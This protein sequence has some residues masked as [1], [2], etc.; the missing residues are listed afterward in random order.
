MTAR[1]PIKTPFFYGWL[2]VGVTFLVSFSEVAF[3]QPV[4][5]V[6]MSPL[7]EEFGWSRA[8]IAGAIGLGSIA[9]GLTSTVV[10]PIIDTWGGRWVMAATGLVI[11]AAL[12]LLAGAHSVVVFYIC[13]IIGRAATVSAMSLAA[14]VTV[15][16]WFIRNRGLAIGV[17]NLGSRI[18]QAVVPPLMAFLVAGFGWRSAFVA[19]GCIALVLAVLPALVFVRRRPE[20]VGLYPDGMPLSVTLA[21]PVQR[22]EVDWSAR[23]A[24]RTRAFWMLTLATSLGSMASA[25]VHLHT[26]PY[27]QDRGLPT[28]V[29]VTVLSL[30]A[31]IGGIGGLFGGLAERLVGARRTFALSLAGQ[32]LSMVILINV[33]SIPMAYL[34]ALCFG[35]AFGMTFT[36]NNMI[37]ATYFGRRSLG[38]IRGLAS[39][40][41]LVFNAAGPFLS[42]LVYDLTGSYLLAFSGFAVSYMVGVCCVLLAAQPVSRQTAASQP[43][44]A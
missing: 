19:L 10:G 18:G 42:G 14:S 3:F 1:V 11:A 9:G 37:F 17:M 5:G 25:S 36:M 20:D 13:Y 23:A 8:T 22:L 24:I 38:A 34:F 4:L 44:P 2:I 15:S 21:T 41:Q 39:P 35:V 27:L 43:A 32:A 28:A 30:F 31:T 26:I 7:H 12:F 40:I 6:F 29:A 33:H 16:N